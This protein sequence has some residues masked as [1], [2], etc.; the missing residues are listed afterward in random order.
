MQ[1]AKAD[2]MIRDV[3]GQSLHEDLKSGDA[4]LAMAWSGDMVHGDDRQARR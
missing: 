2:G 3:K 1:K 4:V